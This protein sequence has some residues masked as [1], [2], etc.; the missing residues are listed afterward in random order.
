MAAANNGNGAQ[1]DER[2]IVSTPGIC[3]GRWRVNGTRITVE[4]LAR[5]RELGSSDDELLEDYPSLTKADLE[6]AWSFTAGESERY[7]C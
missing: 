7:A 1:M 4:V 6:A 5:S 3:G 2:R